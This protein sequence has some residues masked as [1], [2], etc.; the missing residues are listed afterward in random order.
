[1]SDTLPSL[2]PEQFIRITNP[3]EAVYRIYPL[4]F[5]EEVLRLHQL[6]LASP[7]LWDDPFEVV[8]NAI[9]VDYPRGDKYE[10]VIINQ[11]LPPVYAQCWSATQESDTLLRAYSRVIKDPHFSR[12]ICPRDEGVRVRS[13]PRKL[14]EALVKGTQREPASSCF[15]GCVQYLG[16]DTLLQE[17]ANA[18]GTAGLNAFEHPANRAKLLLMKRDAF[19]HEAEVRLMLVRHGGNSSNALLRIHI[20]PSAVFDE[21]SFDP[22]L[23]TFER[24]EREI[25]FR[26]HGYTGQFRESGLYQRVILQVVLPKPPSTS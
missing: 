19:A 12:N 22:R 25:A 2:F 23:A 7:H 24:R 16:K 14:L 20:D 8:G 15:I 13:S 4:W 5:L 3:D 11:S 18:V 17:I 26:N 1:M 10:Q 6:V 21:I 9:A